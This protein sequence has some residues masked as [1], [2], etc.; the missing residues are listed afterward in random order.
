MQ[1]LTQIVDALIS[2]G[3]DTILAR[4][5]AEVLLQIKEEKDHP[6][7]CTF[8]VN[9]NPDHKLLDMDIDVYKLDG[10]SANK[11]LSIYRR[12]IADHLLKNQSHNNQPLNRSVMDLDGVVL[13][14]KNGDIKGTGHYLPVDA[15]AVLEEMKLPEHW[16]TYERLGFSEHCGSR[17]V[18]GI[19]ASYKMKDALIF[20]LSQ[21][22]DSIRIFCEG[23]ILYS[24]KD[25]EI[26]YQ[27]MQQLSEPA[28]P[29]GILQ[30]AY[31]AFAGSS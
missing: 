11:P 12:D 24:P 30:P 7:G 29:A 25:R 13:V 3:K 19:C 4:R 5:T 9:Y 26:N 23:K 2:A 20:V 8:V 22:K 14:A 27:P 15:R 18:S 21:E 10:Y 16:P 6:V 1:E 28:R 31:T 17:H